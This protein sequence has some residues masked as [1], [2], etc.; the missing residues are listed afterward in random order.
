MGSKTL[1]QLLVVLSGVFVIVQQPAASGAASIICP[2]DFILRLLQVVFYL[3]GPA[4]VN[5]LFAFYPGV[6]LSPI[7]KTAARTDMIMVPM[8]PPN[9]NG[10]PFWMPTLQAFTRSPATGLFQALQDQLTDPAFG[11]TDFAQSP[12]RF[13]HYITDHVFNDIRLTQ[14][15]FAF[16]FCI[17]L[18]LFPAV[19]QHRG[20]IYNTPPF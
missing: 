6:Q 3:H 7:F 4:Y 14:I 1:Q 9:K 18:S 20:K 11:K 15:N 12:G 17:G 10:E 13:C 2:A 8:I 16:F 19:I 5:H